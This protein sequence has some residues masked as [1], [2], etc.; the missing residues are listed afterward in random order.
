M[1]KHLCYSML[2]LG[3]FINGI[4]VYSLSSNM[5][6]QL[7]S[8]QAEELKNWADYIV[9]GAGAAGSVVA[10]RLAE[11]PD[12]KILVL[13]LGPNNYGNE[14]IE[15]P[16]ANA[17]LWDNPLGPNPSPT[18][19]AFD[20]TVQQGRS[21]RYPRGTGLGGS[22]NHHSMI[23]GRGSAK[24]YDN[25]AQLVA[26][27]KWSYKSV[28]PYF[29]KMENYKSP[30][31][32]PAFHGSKG[33]L[34]LK[35]GTI[36]A[37]LH[38][39]F[40]H[41]A[42]KVTGA[43]LQKDMSGNPAHSDGIG[44][45]DLQVSSDGKRSAA[46]NDLLVPQI[47][48][49]NNIKVL[50]NTLAT[51]IIIQKTKQGLRAQGVQALYKPQV[52]L[53][54]QSK[55]DQYAQDIS[56]PLIFQFNA[57][58]EVVLSG[59]A[60]NTPQLLLLSGIG[61]ADHLKSFNIPVLLDRPGVGSDLLDHHEVSVVYEVDPAKLVWPA[62]SANIID[63]IDSYLKKEPEDEKDSIIL[64]KLKNYLSQFADRQEQQESSGGVVLDWYSG[65]ESDIGHDL[66]ITGGEGFM[67][68]FDLSSNKPLPDGK[69]RTDYLKAQE[70]LLHPDFLRVFSHYL[71]EVLKVTRADGTIRLASSDPTVPPFVDLSLYKDD[72]AV[73]RMAR[74]IQMIRK[75]LDHPKVKKYYKLDN[76]NKPVE[77]FPGAHVKTIED[78]KNYLKQ[79]S[80]FG[81]H[82]SGT[83]KMGKSNNPQAVV[84][85]NLRVIGIPNLRVIDTSVY[86]YPYLHGYNTARSAYLIGEI[87]SDLIK[88][89]NVKQ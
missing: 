88:E 17:L 72:E 29:K 80:A 74:G 23:D 63:A 43:P 41:A 49:N 73:E 24:I 65:L 35:Q 20:T 86:P 82:I 33:W 38:R 54:D 4:S 13:E 79:W 25:I 56:N 85:T 21:Y 48:K 66:H 59:G 30:V 67:F 71:L 78:L 53:A 6:S 68:D 19:L 28:L 16:S 89:D 47:E 50:F 64:N 22:T 44:I 3:M 9:I 75:I 70:D 55:K 51:R 5:I 26:D 83:A 18:S 15:K 87:G 37:P 84:D 8:E 60:I 32:D 27:D 40:M 7:N 31:A 58:K 77:I 45:V 81:H 76:K 14:W 69:L 42:H 34:Q 62:Q 61:P 10:A 36:K 2:I 1:I 46:F 11:N 57:R 39:D 52:Y 12:N